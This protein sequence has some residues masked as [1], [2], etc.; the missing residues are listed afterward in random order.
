MSNK[1]NIRD[2][3]MYGTVAEFLRDKIVDGSRLSFVSAYFTIN[4]FHQLKDKLTHIDGLRFLFGEP[5]FIQ[6][7]DPTKT[8]SKV[9]RLTEEGLALDNYLPQKEIAKAC[10]EWIEDKVEIRSVAKSNF[11]HGK[12][13]YIEKDGGEDAIIGSSNFTVRGLGLN[14]KR[15]NIELNLEVDSKSD[16]GD[17]KTWFDNLWESD[18]VQDVK[19]DVLRYLEN[20]YTDKDPEFIYFKTLYHLFEDFLTDTTD[21][22]F[23]QSNPKFQYSEI[24]KMLYAFQKHGV[25]ACIQKLKAYNGCIIADS[26]G[27]GKT[28]EALAIIK[29]FEIRGANVLVLCPK[30]LEQ[31]WTLYSL[32]YNRKRNPL[33]KDNFRYTVRSHTDLTDRGVSEDFEWDGFDLVV[34]DESHNFRNRPTDTYSDDGILIRKS[35]YNKLLEDIIQSGCQTQVLMLS[36][37]PVNNKLTDLEN[38]IRLITE[39]NDDAF[40]KTGI[41]SIRETVRTAQNRFEQWTLENGE[42]LSQSR[43]QDSLSEILN[44]DFFNLLD[45][46]TIARSRTH[47]ERFYENSLDEIGGFP[48]REAPI[49]VYPEIDRDGVFP[50]FQDISSQIDG[51]KLSLFNP[52]YYIK[53]DCVHHYDDKVLIHRESNL[54]GMMKV[55]F[56]KRLESSV[57][58]FAKTLERTIEKINVLAI[59]IQDFLQ[60][61]VDSDS[62]YAAF[63]ETE[64]EYG[65][66]D[67]LLN[68]VQESEN[69]FYQY[70]HL[71][72]EKWLT[73]LQNDREQ[74]SKL[75]RSADDIT[76]DRDKK[77]A[78]LKMLISE[79]VRNPITNKDGKENRKVLVFTAFAD[80]ANYLY[81]NIHG[82]ASDTLNIACAVVTGSANKTTFGSTDFNDILTNFSPIAKERA[83]DEELPEIDLLIATD[84]ISEGQNLQDC[85]YLVN[86]DIHWNPVRIIQRFGRID[87]IGSR[88]VKVRLVNF[89]PTPELDEYINLKL[90]VEARMALVN[91]TATGYDNP[92]TPDNRDENLERVW[93][94][95]DEQ[96]RRMQTE[97]LDFDDMDEHLNISQFTLDDFRA[98]LLNY[99]QTREDDLRLAD[100]GLYAVTSPITHVGVPVDIKPG[101]IFCLKQ[102]VADA[103]RRE[104]EKLNPL[105]PYYLVYVKN[106]GVVSIGFTNPKRILERFSALCVGKAL[107]DTV[108]CDWFNAETDNGTDMT[109]YGMLL[110]GA[111]ASI[112][113]AY[114]RR[115]NDVLDSSSDAVLPTAGSQITEETE[116]ELVTWLVVG[117]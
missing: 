47:I 95:R 84:C 60:E 36:A 80:T 18:Q 31:N 74:L 3:D 96:L 58:S 5:T 44:V 72:L 48:D 45:R 87:R 17:L 90:R 100:L 15:S 102:V 54:I 59:D 4:A 103:D 83:T 30:K 91:L 113:G 89:W 94:H 39:D 21:A 25:Q 42:T 98:Q 34:I 16:C 67:D 43:R 8:D 23:A 28:Y 53:P 52:S 69:D 64:A 40:V 66:D 46:L 22:D 65:E 75:F 63:A 73:D 70:E 12:M 86:Y 19:D 110:E 10:A 6:S 106:D 56:L 9:F 93:S 41:S 99:L 108:L 29:Y 109:I 62:D 92:L 49:P 2:N 13:Y 105:H 116:F 32:N 1:S 50:S 115:V 37:T 11:L 82:W 81:E 97:I 114:I 88:N 112:R 76:P 71:D 55:N 104:G 101:V 78:E 61:E 68:G 85:D 35:R 38:Q 111:L 107:P 26:V 14:E 27:L 20:V 79:K 24:W 57:R 7:L 51:Y 77:L 117:R 33:K